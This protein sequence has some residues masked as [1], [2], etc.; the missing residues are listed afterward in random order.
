MNSLF[1]LLSVALARFSQIE[2]VVSALER[3]IGQM[4]VEEHHWS[5]SKKTSVLTLWRFYQEHSEHVRNAVQQVS[6]GGNE[7]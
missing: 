5:S 6:G 2:A 4:G 1:T 7:V 3:Q